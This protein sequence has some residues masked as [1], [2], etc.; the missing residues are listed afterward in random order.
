MSSLGNNSNSSSRRA[1]AGAALHAAGP[2][3]ESPAV[4]RR[5]LPAQRRGSQSAQQQRSREKQESLDAWTQ[6]EPDT[7]RLDVPRLP[8]KITS[9][10]LT[11]VSSGPATRPSE[12]IPV[13]GQLRIGR[14]CNNDVHLPDDNQ[15]SRFHA[16][17]QLHDGKLTIRDLGSTNG[18]VVN[19]EQVKISDLNDLDFITLGRT[20]IRV[21]AEIIPEPQAEPVSSPQ[22]PAGS[23][24][25][26]EWRK[27]MGW[28][29][30]QLAGKIDV[31][32]KTVS[33]WEQGQPISSDRR[34]RL[35]SL[36]FR[37]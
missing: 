37:G 34:D 19:S 24:P 1:A 2:E 32:Q 7:D 12:P 22:E 10:T 35:R 8:G 31:T 20:L 14:D 28:T 25:L 13:P 16:V 6:P 29:Q 23:S 26:R 11:I 5:G 18:T 36:G 30:S 15:V 9:A 17:V 21:H 27:Y 33:Q 4:T 3:R